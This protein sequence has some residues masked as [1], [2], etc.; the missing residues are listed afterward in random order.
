MLIL[1]C[2]RESD[3]TFETLISIVPWYHAYGLMSTINNVL[4]KATIVYFSEGFNPLTYLKCI[5]EYKVRKTYPYLTTKPT[6]LLYVISIF[7]SFIRG[8][9]TIHL[10]S[11]GYSA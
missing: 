8:T 3:K 9:Y 7:L 11:H 1:I 6:R 2:F 4:V 10:T 5:Q